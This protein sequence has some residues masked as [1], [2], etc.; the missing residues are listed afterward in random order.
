MQL[1]FF[2]HENT[3]LTLQFIFRAS[4]KNCD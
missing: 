2:Q 1:H 3:E 4:F